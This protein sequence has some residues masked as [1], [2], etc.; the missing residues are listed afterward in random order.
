MIENTGLYFMT[1]WKYY[2]KQ[3]P[4]RKKRPVPEQACWIRTK[5]AA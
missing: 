3:C 4:Q 5:N 2:K 1:E